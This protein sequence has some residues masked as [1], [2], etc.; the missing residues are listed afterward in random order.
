M[1]HDHDFPDELARIEAIAEACHETMGAWERAHG[2]YS[3]KRWLKSSDE[4]RAEM[5]RD[6]MNVLDGG[7]EPD[8]LARVSA[9]PHYRQMAQKLLQ[10][11]VTGLTA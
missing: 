2:D 1:H 9:L 6:V 8:Y 5:R 7:E 11:I 3:R 4:Q 10:S